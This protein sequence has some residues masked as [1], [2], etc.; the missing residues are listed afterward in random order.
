MEKKQVGG[1]RHKLKWVMLPPLHSITYAIIFAFTCSV[2]EL[3]KSLFFKKH[4]IVKN[5]EFVTTKTGWPQMS[6]TLS[7][8][9]RKYFQ[10]NRR[11]PNTFLHPQR[12]SQG[13]LKVF[14]S[15]VTPF[16][17]CEM[18]DFVAPW[19]KYLNY[20]NYQCLLFTWKWGCLW[21][22]AI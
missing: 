4:A 3:T 1:E 9:W 19:H 12:T 2:L 11:H 7:M 18:V 10:I 6:P 14:L 5:K 20:K 13:K 15:S 8:S 16:P 21:I 22:L 17:S